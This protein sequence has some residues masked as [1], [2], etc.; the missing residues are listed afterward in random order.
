MEMRESAATTSSNGKE[1]PENV[2]IAPDA[3]QALAELA[4][5]AS[6]IPSTPELSVE[7]C[8]IFDEGSPGLDCE[9]DWSVAGTTGRAIA[10]YK[11]PERLKRI[12]L[13]LRAGDWQPHNV[14]RCSGDVSRRLSS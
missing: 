10:H 7:V 1:L 8:R 12:L 14:E 4:E 11:L 2:E 6:Y 3:D 9:V 13:A 5:L